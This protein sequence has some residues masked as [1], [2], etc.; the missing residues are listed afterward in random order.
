MLSPSF[1]A[2]LQ[3]LPAPFE[4]LPQQRA[5]N[6]PAENPQDPPCPA[7]GKIDGI[8]RYF[9]SY[10]SILKRGPRPVRKVRPP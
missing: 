2:P 4:K 1:F 3:Q 6:F 5:E 9:S 8:S 10:L 7:R